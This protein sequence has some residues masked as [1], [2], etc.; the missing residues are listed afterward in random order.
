[1]IRTAQKEQYNYI[2]VIG[3]IEHDNKT[4]NVQYRDKKEK[5]EISIDTLLKDNTISYL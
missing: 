5:K 3:K 1:M 4:I 2:L